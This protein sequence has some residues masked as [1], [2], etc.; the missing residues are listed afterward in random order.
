MKQAKCDKCLPRNE[1]LVTL[2]KNISCPELGIKPVRA[3]VRAFYTELME[4]LT[5]SLR[6]SNSEGYCIT[7]DSHS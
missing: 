5:V 1:V 3:L 2:P 4:Y 6:A 7:A